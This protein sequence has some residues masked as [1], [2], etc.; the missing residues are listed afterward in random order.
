MIKEVQGLRFWA[1][2][3]VVFIHL[4]IIIPKELVLVK[5]AIWKIFHTST[6][7]E[8]FF[9]LAGY[10]M[11]V[12]LE[13]L[14]IETKEKKVSTKLIIEF[15]VKKFRRLAPSAYFW[16]FVALVFSVA[17]NQQALFL[18]PSVMAQKF[19]ATILWFR[20]FNEAAQP[21]HLGYFWAL[22]L[23]FQFFVLFSILYLSLGRKYT[24][25][26]SIV[27]CFIQMFYRPGGGMSWLFRFDPLLY[28]VFVY[29][30]FNYVGKEFFSKIFIHNYTTKV[31]LSILLI[32]SLSAV[33]PAFSSYTNFKITI[34]AL[35]ASFMLILALSQNGHFYSNNKILAKLIDYIASR[36]YAIFCTHIL[37]WC[38]VKYFCSLFNIQNGYVVFTLALSAMFLASEF[39]YR[40]IENMWVKKENY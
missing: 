34:S 21:T 10:F 40:Y 15:I 9:V 39:S 13:K 11:M 22:A 30:L 4:P 18:A 35:T 2:F 12:S 16:A 6:G 19:F 8:L 28:G 3:M 32:L 29:Y 36:S 20:N 26:I 7:V 38:I 31:S 24:L 23:E 14:N 17:T 1:I 25:Y 37:V 5:N 27:L 33:L